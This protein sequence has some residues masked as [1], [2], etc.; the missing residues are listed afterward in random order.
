MSLTPQNIWKEKQNKPT[1]IVQ[2]ILSETRPL[3]ADVLYEVLL[4]RGVFKWFAVRRDLI[5]LK[6]TWK[7]RIIELQHF[8]RDVK[9][10]CSKLNQQLHAAEDRGSH[11]TAIFLR[12]ALNKTHKMLHQAKGELR[13]LESCRASVRALCHSPRWRAPEFD[14]AAVAWLQRKE[15]ALKNYVYHD[16]RSRSSRKPYAMDSPPSTGD[17]N[18]A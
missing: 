16:D 7:H 17:N 9:F 14:K 10:E 15:L 3:T 13:A 1:L 18:A 8:I 11:Q 2:D 6:N 12:I 4:R 5:Q